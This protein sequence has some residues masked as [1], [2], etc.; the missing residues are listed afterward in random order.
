MIGKCFLQSI[1]VQRS[2][3]RGLL[4]LAR[5]FSPQISYTMNKYALGALVENLSTFLVF[6]I[7]NLFDQRCVAKKTITGHLSLNE[8][9]GSVRTRVA[10]SSRLSVG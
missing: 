10:S 6:M 8:A 3:L 9:H 2:Q 4:V 5:N 1:L 7:S